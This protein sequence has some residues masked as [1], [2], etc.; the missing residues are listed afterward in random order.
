MQT[1]VADKLKDIINNCLEAYRDVDTV[2]HKDVCILID[3]LHTRM[4]VMEKNSLLMR[5][6]SKKINCMVSD[7]K[8]HIEKINSASQTNVKKITDTVDN[9]I[10]LPS[11]VRVRDEPPAKNMFKPDLGDAFCIEFD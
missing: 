7:L 8:K 11:N 3:K 2:R 4:D 1:S 10:D 5:E 9:N 6:D